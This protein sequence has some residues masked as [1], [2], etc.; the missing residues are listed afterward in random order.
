M[1]HKETD[2][3]VARYQQLAR[4]PGFRKGKV[5]ASLVRQR[6]AKEIQEDVTEALVPR[7]LREETTKQNLV[8]VSQPRVTDLH[9]EPGEAMRFKASFEVLPEF[10][11]APYEDIRVVDPRHQRH[12]RRG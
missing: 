10:Q 7:Y 12:R 11:V 2:D 9:V 1:V 5:P 8:P 3:I 4:V 6:F